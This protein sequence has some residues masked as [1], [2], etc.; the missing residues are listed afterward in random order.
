MLWHRTAR[1]HFLSRGYAVVGIDLSEHML[2]LA[3]QNANQYLTNGQ[4]QFIRADA[5]R[6]TLPT[7]VGLVT[8]TTDALNH[9]ESLDALRD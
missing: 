6:F 7:Q 2:Q 4:A 5:T 9:L 8:S 1:L 3:G